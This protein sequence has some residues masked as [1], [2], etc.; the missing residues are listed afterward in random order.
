MVI[1]FAPGR[2]I[3]DFQISI[4]PRHLSLHA[5]HAGQADPLGQDPSNPLGLDFKLWEGDNL[6]GQA[7]DC[8]SGSCRQREDM[9]V[10]W[11]HPEPIKHKSETQGLS[12]V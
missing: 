7:N 6:P 3:L 1:A 5:L 9:A 12:A 4:E 8:E 2:H 10:N 11:R